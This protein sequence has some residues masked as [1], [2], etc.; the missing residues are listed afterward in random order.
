MKFVELTQGH[1][2]LIDDDDFELVSQYSW[3]Y[4]FYRNNEYARRSLGAGQGYQGMH[5]LL[6]RDEVVRSCEVDHIDGNGLNNQ[7]INLRV[8]YHSEN[9][10]N[11]RV[12]TRSKSGYRGV[13]HFPK[14]GQWDR[15]KPW[16]ARIKVDGI[17]RTIGYFETPDQA[18][19]AWNEV[20]YEAWGDFARLNV[21]PQ[22]E[23]RR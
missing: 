17:D 7:R 13:S 6:M 22:T 11:Q 10:Q 4:S 2:A 9:I 15:K 3:H 21:I 14:C 1:R 5:T 20:A 18:A 8:V 19:L 23:E 16:R 12:Q